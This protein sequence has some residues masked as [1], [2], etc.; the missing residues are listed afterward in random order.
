M[1]K[2]RLERGAGR[3]TWER[4]RDIRKQEVGRVKRR[5]SGEG[6]LSIM[7]IVTVFEK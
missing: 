2:E 7:P 1:F 3:G 5:D 4:I 6:E